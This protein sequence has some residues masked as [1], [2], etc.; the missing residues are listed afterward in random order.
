MRVKKVEY[1]NGYKLRLLFNDKK[2]KI[3]DI[4]P[5][6]NS[7]RLFHPLKEI[8][9]FK[10]VSLD[11]SEYPASICWPNGVDICPDYLYELGIDV[12]EQEPPTKPLA[13]RHKQSAIRN[14][15]VKGSP[16]TKK[17]PKGI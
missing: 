7:K 11:D 1:V 2:T 5:I 4:E 9:Y 15:R 14:V 12:E 3:V 10:R 16:V 13:K 8:E 17:H 6:I